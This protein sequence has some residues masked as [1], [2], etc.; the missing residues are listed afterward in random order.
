LNITDESREFTQKLPLECSY[1]KL[2]KIYFFAVIFLV[3]CSGS[4]SAETDIFRDSDNCLLCHGYPTIGK[5]TKSGEPRVFYVN[6]REYANTVH[7]RLRCSQ[8]HLGLDKIPHKDIKKVDCSTECHISGSGKYRQVSHKDVVDKYQASVHGTGTEENPKAFPDDL[9]TCTYCHTNRDY[10]YS[11]KSWDISRTYSDKTTSAL[12]HPLSELRSQ[13][14]VIKLCASC[15]EDREKMAR[16]GLESIETY[17]DTF[18]WEQLKYGVEDSPDCIREAIRY[19]R[20]V[21]KTDRKPASIREEY[22]H[23][24]RTRLPSLLKAESILMA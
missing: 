21:V 9:P 17:R 16:H 8:C 18:H 2:I 13:I 7:G 23:V 24:I 12:R 6:G 22:R 15:H 10:H 5:Q 19:L 4:V 14:D 11:E 3:I 20:L 1:L